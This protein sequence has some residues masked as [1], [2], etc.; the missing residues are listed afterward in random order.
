M[1]NLMLNQ[2][3][4]IS[5]PKN[6]KP[7]SSFTL[8]ALF[9]LKNN[10]IKKRFFLFSKTFWTVRKLLP[11]RSEAEKLACSDKKVL[12]SNLVPSLASFYIRTKSRLKNRVTTV[13]LLPCKTNSFVRLCF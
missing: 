6:E 3:A 1:L 11:N 13:H 10:L 12:L 4:P 2:L 5:N 9:H 8:I 7:K